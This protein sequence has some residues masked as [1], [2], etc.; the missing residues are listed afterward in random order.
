M[1]LVRPD[2]TIFDEVRKIKDFE[3]FADLRLTGIGMIG[4][5]HASEALDA[6][7]RFIGKIELGY[8]STYNRYSNF[9]SRRQD[10]KNI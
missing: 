7:Q 8:D 5:I 10:R 4:V 9:Y 1:L 3:L 6:I 2:F